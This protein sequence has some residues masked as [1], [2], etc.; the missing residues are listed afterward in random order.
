M[1][2]EGRRD[3]SMG[4]ALSLRFYLLDEKFGKIVEKPVFYI[5]GTIGKDEI[6]R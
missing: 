6:D 4:T 1:K 3:I 5:C 2:R